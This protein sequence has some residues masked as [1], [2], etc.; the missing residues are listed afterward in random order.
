[1]N[2]ILNAVLILLLAC[3][4]SPAFSA[5]SSAPSNWT[6]ETGDTIAKFGH[7]SVATI[8]EQNQCWL[9]SIPT[10]S[11]IDKTNAPQD[12][13]RGTS[14]LVIN[15][16]AGGNLHGEFSYNSGYHFDSSQKVVLETESMNMHLPIREKGTAWTLG[17]TDD[18]TVIKDFG[19]N[20]YVAVRGTTSNSVA[21]GDVFSLS[22]FLAALNRAKVECGLI[23]LTS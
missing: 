18:Q 6:E 10:E 15:F 4:V 3:L 12:F 14:R 13:C 5:C 21:V 19:L 16:F 2:R 17:I 23:D 8:P 7:W 11:S 20:D 9:H 22:G 1:M